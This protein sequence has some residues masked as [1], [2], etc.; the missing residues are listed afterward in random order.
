MTCKALRAVPTFLHGGGRRLG[1]GETGR[2]GLSPPDRVSELGSLH[3]GLQEG[4]SVAPEMGLRRGTPS[5]IGCEE[6]ATRVRSDHLANILD[7]VVEGRG[8]QTKSIPYGA[9]HCC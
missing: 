6:L 5:H 1:L 3:L 2:G 4:G 8:S 7:L 9:E